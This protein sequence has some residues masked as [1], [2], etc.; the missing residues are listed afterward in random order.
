MQGTRL[1]LREDAAMVDIIGI[2]GMPGSGK[3]VAL[4]TLQEHFN[5][6]IIN[7]GN[8]VREQVTLAGLELNPTTLGEMAQQLREDR[9]PD[10][11]A[12]LTAEKIDAV[13]DDVDL[14][15]IDGLRS[16]QEVQF[17][18]NK[19]HFPVLAVHSPPEVRHS[20]MKERSREDDSSEEGYFKMR[21]ERELGF[22]I[23]KVIALANAMVVNG[24]QTTI[25]DLQVEIIS[26]VK[27]ITKIK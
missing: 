13:A 16:M 8:M 22:G 17:F 3:S 9:G 20:R 11:V 14:V 15:V 5:A 4:E 1:S 26:E 23:A 7:M 10:V 24:A 25:K 6:K 19:W 2:V 27:R 18:R 12:Q 21:D